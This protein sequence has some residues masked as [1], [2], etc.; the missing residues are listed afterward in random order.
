MQFAV[1]ALAHIFHHF[2]YS[3]ILFVVN[4]ERIRVTKY[5]SYGGAPVLS[6]LNIKV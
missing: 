2:G 5:R 3:R 1:I 4:E 6:I